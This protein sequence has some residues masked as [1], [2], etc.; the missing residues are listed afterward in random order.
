M[1]KEQDGESKW[2]VIKFLKCSRSD[3]EVIDHRE[4]T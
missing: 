2:V 4:V 3:K 1:K